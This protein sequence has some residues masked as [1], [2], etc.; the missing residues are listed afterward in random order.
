MTDKQILSI[1]VK[2]IEKEVKTY[3]SHWTRAKIILL[4]QYGKKL[5]FAVKFFSDKINYDCP[6]VILRFNHLGKSMVFS[7]PELPERLMEWKR[8]AIKDCTQKQYIE[9]D[10]VSFPKEI[11]HIF[12]SAII[13]ALNTPGMS[14]IIPISNNSIYVFKPNETYEEICVEAD[15]LEFTDF[16]NL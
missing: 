1:V 7:L 3:N 4:P 11:V 2:R 5:L 15:L 8:N 12:S 13:S 9:Y 16:E 14:M 10:P 6:T